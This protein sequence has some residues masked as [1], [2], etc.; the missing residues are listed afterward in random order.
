MKSLFYIVTLL[1]SLLLCRNTVAASEQTRSITVESSNTISTRPIILADWNSSYITGEKGHRQVSLDSLYSLLSELSVAT[2]Q[3]KVNRTILSCELD[4]DA[5]STLGASLDS[6]L[7]VL[8]NILKTNLALY[9]N[10]KESLTVLNGYKEQQEIKEGL[11]ARAYLYWILI[12]I[13][14]LI[15]VIFAHFIDATYLQLFSII[16]FAL[17]VVAT[18]YFLQVKWYWTI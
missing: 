2:R 11:E 7:L 13:I 3:V 18:L 14:A 10:T 9:W 6:C 4:D 12:S 15:L 16:L 17:S 8:N 5:I 1:L